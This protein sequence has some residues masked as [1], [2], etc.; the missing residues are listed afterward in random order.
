VS[1]FDKT[2]YSLDGENFVEYVDPLTI[3]DEGSTEITYYAVDKAGNKESQ[4]TMTIKID[5]TAPEAEITYDLSKFDVIVTGKDNFS[6]VKVN[7]DT[8]SKLNPKYTLTDLAGNTL[9]IATGEL[10]IGKQVTQTLKTLKYNSNPS[11][12]L[13]RNIFF[14]L[15]FAD[16]NNVV[17][18]L[19]QYVSMKGDKRIFT[20]YSSQT[21]ITKIFTKNV[22]TAGYTRVDKQ[23]IVLLKL[24]TEKGVV[25][26]TY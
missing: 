23:G 21:N 10:Q 12:S 5:K 19:D 2:F 17:K 11:I 14:T 1:G 16:R 9:L 8:S 22:G 13:D 6:E 3:V 25:K 18:Q 15:V 24:Y 20:N 7:V 4:K 26:Y